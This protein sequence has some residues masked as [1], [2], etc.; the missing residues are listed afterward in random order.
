MT[1]K[2]AVMLRTFLLLFVVTFFT[3]ATPAIAAESTLKK[4]SFM[5]LWSPQAQFAGFYTALEKGIYRKHGID[6]TIIPGGPDRPTI[7]YLR[8]GRA[9]FAALWLTTA[10]QERAAGTQLVNLAQI[11]QQSSMMLVAKKTS[12]ITKPT[13]MNGKKVGLWGGPFL[14]PPQ[15]FFKKHGLKVR[16]VPQS[17]T[18]NLFLRGGIDLTSAMWY[19]EYHTILNAGLDPDELNIFMLKDHGIN[20]LEDGIYALE[21]TVGR[22][23]ALA[24]A[25]VQASLEG[26]QHAFSHPDEALDIVI[27]QMQIAKIPASRVHQKWMLERMRDL[28]SP[29]AGFGILKQADYEATGQVLLQQD[30]ISRLPG[31]NEF[32]GGGNARQ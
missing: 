28:I 5:P 20:L 4:A 2:S 32:V 19:N 15:A 17:Y 1:V 16:V 6:L 31:F 14:L 26:W 7:E 24:K 8:S 23:P 9:D 13:D 21:G 27:K 11:I 25:F 10:I 3:T 29:Q 12:G 18:I 30:V 22:D